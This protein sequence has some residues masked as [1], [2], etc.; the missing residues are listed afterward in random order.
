MRIGGTVAV[1]TGRCGWHG[2]VPPMGG[3][4]D[5]SGAARV[6]GAV[7]HWRGSDGW[8]GVRD[9]SGAEGGESVADRRHRTRIGET[10]G[11]GNRE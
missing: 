5:L 4:A 3:R 10:Q 9:V 8:A 2:G 6:D 7:R 1:N 11:M